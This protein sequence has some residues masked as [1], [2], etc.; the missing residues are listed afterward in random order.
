MVWW[1]SLGKLLAF[2]ADLGTFPTIL[3]EPLL[4]ESGPVK[5]SGT[6]FVSEMVWPADQTRKK[7]LERSSDRGDRPSLYWPSL[8]PSKGAFPL[9]LCPCHSRR[10]FR[11][12]PS[13]RSRASSRKVDGFRRWVLNPFLPFP[14]RGVFPEIQKWD[15]LWGD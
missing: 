14:S 1:H 12:L 6:A 10:A 2:S 4:A 7:A 11:K 5:V 8:Q 9:P 3:E 13:A 15:T